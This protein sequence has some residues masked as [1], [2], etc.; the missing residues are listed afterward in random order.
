MSARNEGNAIIA[1]LPAEAAARISAGLTGIMR[2]QAR[3][4]GAESE[5][6]RAEA[7]QKL[8]DLTVQQDYF[9]TAWNRPADTIMTFRLGSRCWDDVLGILQRAD[10]THNTGEVELVIGTI[11]EACLRRDGILGEDDSITL[12]DSP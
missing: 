11:Q 3:I 10:I 9:A 2:M 5:R 7:L 12:P 4:A 6:V 8:S 1:D